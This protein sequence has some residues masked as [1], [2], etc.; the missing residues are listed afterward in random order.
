VVILGSC[1][2][3]GVRRGVGRVSRVIVRG[4]HLPTAGRQ[5]ELHASSGLRPNSDRIGEKRHNSG[6]R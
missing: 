1:R 3:R 6:G 4:H 5:A 2:W